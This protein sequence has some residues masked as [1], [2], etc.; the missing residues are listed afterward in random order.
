MRSGLWPCTHCTSR[1]CHSFQRSSSL[2]HLRT[3]AK[4]FNF[5]PWQ[6]MILPRA[7][8][9]IRLL[10]STTLQV[11]SSQFPSAS[12]DCAPQPLPVEACTH[13]AMARTH[14]NSFRT[15]IARLPGPGAR[16]HGASGASGALAY[17][18][19]VQTCDPLIFQLRVHPVLGSQNLTW[20]LF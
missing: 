8:G 20:F 13:A 11:R 15:A 18:T 12:H 17:L 19:S 5:Q 7:A 14:K 10:I 9:F 4:W 6:E 2:S 16:G 3:S 1:F